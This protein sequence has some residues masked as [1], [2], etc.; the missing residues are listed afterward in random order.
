MHNRVFV[1][2]LI[3]SSLGLDDPLVLEGTR[4]HRPV[5]AERVLSV[6]ILKKLAN[7]HDILLD[8]V[9]VL[10]DQYDLRLCLEDQ[11]NVVSMTFVSN[12]EQ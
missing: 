12:K 4:L 2:S 8:A 3:G 5:I 11:G 10:L 7:R 1:S 9:R 6:D